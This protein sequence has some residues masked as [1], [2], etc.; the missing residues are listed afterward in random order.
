MANENGKSEDRKLG[1]ERGITRR[2]FVG[3]SLIGAGTALLAM[4]SPATARRAQA[5]EFA[6]GH[7]M[8]TP[9][10]GLDATL[11]GYGGIGDYASSNGNTY[12][13]I[14]AAH[15]LRKALR[16]VVEPGTEAMV[17]GCA[18]GHVT[19]QQSLE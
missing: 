8:P 2:D 7:T 19:R 16:R 9:L 15:A 17:N 13:E 18:T 1:L 4:N 3:G 10:A 6:L 12:A 5:A 11:S 14:N